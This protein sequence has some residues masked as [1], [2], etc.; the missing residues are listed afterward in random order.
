MTDE[1]NDLAAYLAALVA[2]EQAR[3][4]GLLPP[5]SLAEN[6]SEFNAICARSR[7]RFGDDPALDEIVNHFRALQAAGAAEIAGWDTA[8][9]DIEN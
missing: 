3:A 1:P 6:V 7:A 4:D 9:L 5:R 2:Y 8:R